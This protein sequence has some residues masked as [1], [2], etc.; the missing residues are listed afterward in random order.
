MAEENEKLEKYGNIY[1]VMLMEGDGYYFYGYESS[2]NLEFDPELQILFDKASEG[3][4]SFK[5]ALE[6]R[7]LKEGG[8]PED[9]EV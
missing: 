3:I 9:Y 1:S 6:D 7:I 8:S 2:S 4:E 5:Q